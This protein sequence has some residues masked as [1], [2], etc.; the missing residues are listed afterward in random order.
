MKSIGLLFIAILLLNLPLF[1]QKKI[2]YPELKK[3]GNSIED[4]VPYGWALW[5]VSYGDLNKDNLQ[6]AVVVVQNQDIVF[7]Q[8]KGTGDNAIEYDANPRV[9]MVL[10]KN[11]GAGYTLADFNNTFIMRNSNPARYDP[12]QA[13]TINKNGI[14]AIDYHFCY[15]AGDRKHTNATYKFRYQN[16]NF[17]LIGTEI[18]DADAKTGEST[19]Y[20]FNFMTRKMCITKRNL[21]KR[22][23]PVEEWQNFELE[24]LKNFKTLTQPFTWDINEVRL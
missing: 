4:F 13:V 2:T 5:A 21:I 14:L 24:A 9:L 12:F 22:T 20:S 3:T 1:G 23:K 6:D 8:T 10:L 19:D 11:K 16:N 17:E 7:V 18:M 15:V